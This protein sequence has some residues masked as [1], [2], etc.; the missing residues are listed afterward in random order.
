MADVLGR[1]V[2]ELVGDATKLRAALNEAKAG[3]NDL[4]ASQRNISKAAF[5]AN[6]N[7]VGNLIAQSA[8][9][10]KTKREV[11]LFG[12]ALRGASKSQIAAA[13][14]ALL[15]IERYE[16]AQKT[17][18]SVA[19][20]AAIAGAAIAA[21]LVGAF[22]A[23]DRLIHKASEFQGLAE[24]I[25]DSASNIAGFSVALAAGGIS[26][27]IF[28]AAAVRLT[29]NLTGVDDDSKKAG[30]AIQALGLNLAQFKTLSPTEQFKTLAAALDGFADGPA[31][32][33]VAVALLGQ[34]GA[35]MLPFLRDLNGEVGVQNILSEEQIQLADGY[36]KKSAIL[37]AQISLYAQAVATEMLPAY[38][39][40]QG[41]FLDLIKAMAG[42]DEKSSE[43]KNSH[44]IRDFANDAALSIAELIDT[45]VSAASTIN[46]FFRNIGHGIAFSSAILQG[47]FSR[48]REM[49]ALKAEDEKQ[50]AARGARPSLLSFVQAR[51][52]ARAAGVPVGAN[53]TP[54]HDKRDL[55]FSGAA[56]KGPHGP[57]PLELARQQARDQLAFDLQQIRQ[58]S[59]AQLNAFSNA[60]KIME[61]MRGANLIDDQK[62]YAAKLGFI[63]LNAQEQERALQAEIERLQ[64]E[65]FAGK[66]A[67]KDRLENERKI[68]DAQAKLSKVRADAAANIQINSIQEQ[69]ALKKIEQAYIDA[70]EAA[71]AYLETIA[72]Q[73]AREIEGI[74]RG[75]KF[76]ERQAGVSAIED[77][78]IVERRRL[79][80]ELRKGQI[81]RAQFDA[82]LEI[83]NDTYRKEIEAYERRT[84]TLL[85]KESDWTNGA[86][87]ALRNY[88]DEAKNIAKQTEDLFSNAFKGMEDA[89]VEFASTGKLNFK[90]LADSIIRDVNRMLIRQN[91]TGPLAEWLQATG[92]SGASPIQIAKN[93]FSGGVQKPAPVEERNIL[94]GPGFISDEHA[95]ALG[96]AATG[97]IAGAAN[98]AT[99]AAT[100]AS[101][102]ATFAAEV[103]TAGA[104]MAA[105]ISAAGLSQSAE[106]ATAGAA[107]AA[108]VTAAGAAFAASVTAASATSSVGGGAGIIGTVLD[109]FA[110]GTDYVPKTG[111]YKLHQGEKVVPAGQ[112]GGGAPISIVINNDWA[113]GTDMQ[114]VAQASVEQGQQV[115]R[116]MQRFG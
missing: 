54:P 17:I 86:N 27:D 3:F 112:A 101:S 98:D 8:T 107:F 74:G 25:G 104:G 115:R 99:F 38:N 47:E 78:Q 5:A 85:E 37:R 4:A 83:V 12:L 40:L 30:A 52:A 110:D 24:T 48:A 57:D 31:K 20:T 44:S 23:F 113:P 103:T 64:R 11:E 53:E 51:I 84:A 32:A 102:G 88:V 35:K 94:A 55:Q 50:E 71:Q 9:I 95:A 67:D 79:E 7:Y 58:A 21:G 106:I 76:R 45:I 91:I 65:T 60:S 70:K 87:E 42:V 41:G 26:A 61:A 43:L 56:K 69:A 73:N 105:E 97:S 66:H 63:Q 59:D 39:D 92:S 13:D 29:K 100:V 1:G 68:L 6:N 72:R 80:S 49:L 108:E 19:K 77:K 111:L 109:S 96:R 114:T 10:G 2:I 15:A 16:T 34:E 116:Q 33:A 75:N 22:V 89:L 81:D 93:I 46:N 36:A 18:S 14:T 82:Y 62:Y 90:S 28:A